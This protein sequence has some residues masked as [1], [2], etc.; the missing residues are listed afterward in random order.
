MLG[1]D[2]AS[3]ASL[4]IT[5][6]DCLHLSDLELSALQRLG[7]VVGEKAIFVILATCPPGQHRITAVGFLQKEAKERGREATRAVTARVQPPRQKDVKL[8]VAKYGGGDKES[9]LRWFVEIDAT[10]RSGQIHDPEQLGIPIAFHYLERSDIPWQKL[11]AS[12]VGHCMFRQVR[13]AK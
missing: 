13:R 8:D 5:R 3:T 7:K 4:T 1:V 9:L 6:D 12:Q 11:R 10:I 2:P